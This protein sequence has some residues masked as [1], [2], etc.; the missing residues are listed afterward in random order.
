MIT[1]P[2]ST[3]PLDRSPSHD[4]LAHAGVQQTSR[5]PATQAAPSRESDVTS[6]VEVTISATARDLAARESQANTSAS[7]TPRIDAS[8]PPQMVTAT[9]RPDAT[10]HTQSSLTSQAEAAQK[11]ADVAGIGIEQQTTSLLRASV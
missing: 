1:T 4:V 10:E 6:S 3:L 8:Q 9:E 7:P 5:G 11:F 2:S